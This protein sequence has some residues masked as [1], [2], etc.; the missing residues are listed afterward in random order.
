M[1]QR[2]TLSSSE[3]ERLKGLERENRELKRATETLREAIAPWWVSFV[4][5]PPRLHTKLDGIF[6]ASLGANG[7]CRSLRGGPSTANPTILKRSYLVCSQQSE[8]RHGSV[9]RLASAVGEGAM[10]VC[11][12][13]PT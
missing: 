8:V 5:L 3:R 11:S 9:K 2:A 10:A 7:R 13:T 12:S 4:I 1:R 6:L